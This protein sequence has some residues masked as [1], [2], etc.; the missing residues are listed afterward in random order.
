MRQSQ[1]SGSV[2]LSKM[3]RADSKSLE[4]LS[5]LRVELGNDCPHCGGKT[6]FGD[7]CEYCGME[8]K[9]TCPKCGNKQAPLSEYCLKCKRPVA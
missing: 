3:P 6:F 8:L 1:P 9:V 5:R 4:K 7:Y 2:A